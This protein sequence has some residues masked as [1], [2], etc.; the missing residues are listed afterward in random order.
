MLC[1]AYE[2]D[3]SDRCE[4]GGVEEERKEAKIN[5]GEL[6]LSYDF[7]P[8]INELIDCGYVPV[9]KARERADQRVTDE[10]ERCS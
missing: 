7:G 10:E 1:G 4:N 6:R 3:D 5:K 2:C 9:E 8:R